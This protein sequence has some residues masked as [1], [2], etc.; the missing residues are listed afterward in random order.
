MRPGPY[1]LKMTQDRLAERKFLESNGVPVAPWRAGLAPRWSSGPPR[2]SSAIP[3]G[4]RRTIGGYDGR[5]QHRLA[6]P[7]EVEAASAAGRSTRR[8]LLER[9]LAFR[10]SCPSS[11]AATCRRDLLSFP[12]PAN[13]HDDGILVESVVAGGGR[14]RGRWRPPRELAEHLATGMGLVGV[15]DRRAVPDADGSLVVNELAPRVHNS[16]HWTI[17]GA[18]TSQFEQHVRAICGLP[19]GS[20]EMRRRPRRWST[21]SAA[22]A[23][24]RRRILAG[25]ATR[26]AVPDVA[27]PPVRQARRLRA[28]EDG[29]RDRARRDDGRSARPRPRGGRARCDV[30]RADGDGVSGGRCARR[31]SASSAAAA[32]TSRS[33]RRRLRSS[34]MLDVPFELRVVSAHRSPD[35][36]FRY[37]ED[38]GRARASA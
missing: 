28:P 7:E 16:G 27:P 38:G 17:E 25:I 31:S 23:D 37:A 2:P 5:S 18:A 14:R 12:P 36:L 10:R 30:G 15:A 4:S 11:S 3:S 6:N 9:E 1:P 26:S 19:L 29:P 24:A 22:G 32:R 13:L 21:C 8:P 34:T 35:H 20:I 33:S